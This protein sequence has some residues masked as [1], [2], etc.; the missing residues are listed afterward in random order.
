AGL[1]QQ[2]ER[3]EL[4]AHHDGRAGTVAVE[5]HDTGAAHALGD[6]EAQRAQLGRELLGGARF[7]EAE[8]GISMDVLVERLD[9]RVLGIHAALDGG[10][11]GG[12]I[13]RL[14]GMS[15]RKRYDGKPPT[16]LQGDHASLRFKFSLNQ[17]ARPAMRASSCC[18][19]MS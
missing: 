11:A 16:G 7:L 13:R 14:S 1:L 19:P 6:L 8:L 9:A 4:G 3:I 15:Q 10:L 17:R 5:P 18:W 2:G 12:K